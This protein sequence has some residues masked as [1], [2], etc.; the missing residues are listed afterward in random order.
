MSFDAQDNVDGVIFLRTNRF[1]DVQVDQIFNSETGKPV[2][3]LR[4][5]AGKR[6]GTIPLNAKVEKVFGQPEIS[7]R[8]LQSVLNSAAA[9]KAFKQRIKK[10]PALKAWYDRKYSRVSSK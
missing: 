9:E 2:K 4:F 5:E 8:D 10:D 7:K 3:P 1:N 6:K